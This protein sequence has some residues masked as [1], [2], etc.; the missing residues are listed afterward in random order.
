MGFDVSKKVA[1]I[2]D[3]GTEEF[4]GTTLEGIGQSVVGVLEHPDETANRFVTVMSIRTCQNE[5]L[6]AFQAAT[7]EPW[8]VKRS[9]TQ[10][11]KESGVRK[12]EA[13]TGGWTLDLAVAQLL[14]EGEARSVVAPSWAES[15]SGLLGVRELT[16]GE[17]V[18]KVLGM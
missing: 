11:M 1:I 5:L 6:E 3:K 13:K 12:M 10:A 16:P 9:T 18:A 2:Y 7:N 8:E 4:T 17:V 14:D 15:D